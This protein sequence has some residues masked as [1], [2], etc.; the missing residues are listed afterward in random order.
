MLKIV[1]LAF[2]VLQVVVTFRVAF[3][4][5]SPSDL[6]SVCGRNRKLRYNHFEQIDPYARGLIDFQQ[7]LRLVSVFRLPVHQRASDENVFFGI[8]LPAYR[9][10]IEFVE[11]FGVTFAASDAFSVF[12]H[13]RKE[14]LHEGMK[15]QI[16]CFDSVEPR[17]ADDTN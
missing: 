7:F 9:H 1:F 11:P 16:F 8:S 4:V 5:M 3:G 14:F 10:Q 13:C 12:F 2:Y 15:L 17:I 6:S